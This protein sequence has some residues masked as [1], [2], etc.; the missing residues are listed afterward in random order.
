M[1][2]RYQQVVEALN[3]IRV[4]GRVVAVTGLLVRAEGLRVSIGA[5]CQIRTAAGPRIMCQV[6]GFRDD[7]ALLMPLAETQGVAEND[8]VYSEPSMQLV[9]VG[10]ALLGRVLNGLGQPL[11]GGTPIHPEA[12]YPVLMN[13]PP[14]MGRQVIDQPL[15]TGIRV[16]D[17]MLTIGTGQRIGIFAG[18]GVGKSVLLGMVSRYTSADVAVIALVGERSREVLDFIQ[19]EL[20]PDG[21]RKAVLVVST[22]DESPI[23]RVRACFVATAIAEY[24]RDQGQQVLLLMDSLTRLAMAQRQIGLAAGEPPATK[25][26]TPSVFALLPR[27]LE[28]AGRTPRGSI[29]GVYSVLVEGDDINEPISDAVRGILDGHIWLSRNLAGKGHYPAVDTLNSI[30]RLMVD[31]VDKPHY[32]AAQVV[33]RVLGTWND[34]EDLVNIGAYAKGTNPR[35][36]VAID[37]KPSIDR[38]LMQAIE[39][40]AELAT[41][42]TGLIQLADAISVAEQKATAR[43]RRTAPLAG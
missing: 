10:D 11:D 24:F 5:M 3:P 14:A 6:V 15:G 31:V 42:R 1:L 19:K 30:S 40:R 28:R 2:G 25:G 36:D 43:P 41:S 33:R 21:L 8:L 32:Q 9:A 35:F 34:I 37:M 18:T 26:Y 17:S 13:A 29:T 16:I 20:G 27:L 22:S 38:F 4:V 23:M 7:Q 12:F 39:D